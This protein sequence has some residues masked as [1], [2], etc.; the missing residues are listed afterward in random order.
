M[1]KSLAHPV[2]LEVDRPPCQEMRRLQSHWLVL[3]DPQPLTQPREIA[4]HVPWVYKGL[5]RWRFG[6][7][8]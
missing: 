7:K 2:Q 5:A 1:A 8:A 6:E 3:G 4:T